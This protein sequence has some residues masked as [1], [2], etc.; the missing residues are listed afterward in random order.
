MRRYFSNAPKKSISGRIRYL[1]RK[2]IVNILLGG[3]VFL[4]FVVAS[5]YAALVQMNT[6]PIFRPSQPPSVAWLATLLDWDSGTRQTDRSV[7]GSSL[8]SRNRVSD[9]EAQLDSRNSSNKIVAPSSGKSNYFMRDETWFQVS[10]DSALGV[11][12]EID[13]TDSSASSINT[14]QEGYAGRTAFTPERHNSG[15]GDGSYHLL[16]TDDNRRDVWYCLVAG[17]KEYA[18][19]ALVV[20]VLSLV[21]GT[22][23]GVML[24]YFPG[25]WMNQIIGFLTSVL[26]S[27]PRLFLLLVVSVASGFQIIP[28][29]VALGV[30][31]AP[32]VAHIIR[33]RVVS[34]KESSFVEAAKEM[35]LPD[36]KIIL[37]HILWYNCR[38]ILLVEVTYAFS[39][40]ILIEAS[41]DYLGLGVQS[42][43]AVTWGNMLS[44]AKDYLWQGSFWF[45]LTPAIAIVTTIVGIQL[46]GDGLA[47]WFDVK[48]LEVI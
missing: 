29:M 38:S 28:I 15:L 33:A 40:V 26:D 16:G 17:S 36:W 9:E 37:K 34:L 20:I 43:E 42:A 18:L 47:R 46:L 10:S 13:R 35:G 48:D 22:S 45:T 32:R 7:N 8:S 4:L 44:N 1:Q 14:A 3:T 11:Q 27:L 31:N 2:G 30:L 19:P 6:G 24:G 23:M 21:I 12:K 5:I 41:L 25:Q 39:L